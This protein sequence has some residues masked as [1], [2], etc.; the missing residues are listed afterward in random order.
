MAS[1]Q[2]QLAAQAPHASFRKLPKHLQGMG[3]VKKACIEI[4]RVYIGLADRI[5]WEQQVVDTL[6]AHKPPPVDRILLTSNISFDVNF[7]GR[8]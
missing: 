7:L 3:G 5:L 1:Q 4:P 6:A 8:L 2:L